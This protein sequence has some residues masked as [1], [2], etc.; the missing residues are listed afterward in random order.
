MLFSRFHKDVNDSIGIPNTIKGLTFL[1]YVF[2]PYKEYHRDPGY[3]HKA[4]VLVLCVISLQG[5]LL[6][7]LIP[8]LGGRSCFLCFRYTGSTIGIL[9]QTRG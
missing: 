1:F 2:S 7:F 6:A 5:V 9:I 4:D 8:S 3:H